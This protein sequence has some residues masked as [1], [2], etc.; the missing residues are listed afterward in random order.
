MM[1]SRLSQPP[2]TPPA[3]RS[4]SSL[5]PRESGEGKREEESWESGMH[6]GYEQPRLLLSLRR[7]ES[8]SP[9]PPPMPCQS[10][11]GAAFV[12]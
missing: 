4:M 12:W 10:P 8:S 7:T 11:S 6:A 1:A 9:A 5:Q 3:C 2:R